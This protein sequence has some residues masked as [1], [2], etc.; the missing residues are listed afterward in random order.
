MHS[1][2][3][4]NGPCSACLFNT[5]GISTVLPVKAPETGARRAGKQAQSRDVT[6][7]RR[8]LVAVRVKRLRRESCS[9]KSTEGVPKISEC[10]KWEEHLL[11]CLRADTCLKPRK[12]GWRS[13]EYSP[14]RAKG[15][16]K[17]ISATSV[18]LQPC[19]A[20]AW[21]LSLLHLHR[22]RDRDNRESTQQCAAARCQSSV[23]E[24]LLRTRHGVT[25]LSFSLL[26]LT[27]MRVLDR[28]E[29]TVEAPD[30]A[31]GEQQGWKEWGW[32]P[33]PPVYH[34]QSRPEMAVTA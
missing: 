7:R 3:W 15:T 23:W 17:M 18:Q 9:G 27:R 28:Q 32:F 13:E 16:K 33:T 12:I 30:E 10:K 6:G 29:A 26:L 4:R 22:L 8:R 25:N 24:R 31:R 1:S 5:T 19:C 11:L 14:L 20:P 2:I 21:Q 34:D